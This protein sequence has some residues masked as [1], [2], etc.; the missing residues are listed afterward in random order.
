MKSR[1]SLQDSHGRIR[2]RDNGWIHAGCQPHVLLL[3][4]ILIFPLSV[5]VAFTFPHGKF[6]F[7]VA[8]GELVLRFL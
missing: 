5:G 6:N 4:D 8:L 3:F 7:I 1:R 2:K